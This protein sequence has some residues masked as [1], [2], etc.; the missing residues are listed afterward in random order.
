[1]EHAPPV[2]RDPLRDRVTGLVA[3]LAL[4]T[5]IIFA[6]S[7]LLPRGGPEPT[8]RSGLLAAMDGFFQHPV[9][10]VLILAGPVAAFLACA[11]A[12]VGIRVQRFAGE[13]VATL[14]VRVRPLH[15]LAMAVSVALLV[16]FAVYLIAENLV[17]GVGEHL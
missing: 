5:P 11:V 8:G 15:L 9:G 16:L 13:P 4:A 3:A 1:M 14:A 6:V 2:R 17:P 12:V 10:E 7:Q